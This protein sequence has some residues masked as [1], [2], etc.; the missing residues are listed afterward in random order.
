MKTTIL[1]LIL[2]VFT[3]PCSA[4]IIIVDDDGPADFNNVQSA[5]DDSNDGDIIVLFPGQYS[6]SGNRD[7]YFYGRAITVSSVAPE[8]EYIVS[9]TIVDCERQGRG[10]IFQ[11]GEDAN[12]VLDGL[13]ITNGRAGRG[14]GIYCSNNSSP[15]ISNCII[16][17]NL[18]EGRPPDL[19]GGGICCSNSS[20]IITWCTI[21]GNSASQGA[22][23][24]C[25]GPST[26]LIDNCVINDNSGD[27][28]YVSNAS[29]T[30][31][32]CTINNNSSTGVHSTDANFTLGYCDINL[33][34][35]SGIHC[36]GSTIAINNCTI[37][38]NSADKGGGIYCEESN[39]T[40]A[41]CSI[42]SNSAARDGGGIYCEESDVSFTEC[43]ITRNS[44][45]HEGGGICAEGHDNILTIS[46]CT[47]AGNSAEIGG[48]MYSSN[49]YA[50]LTNCTFSGNQSSGGGGLTYAGGMY[51]ITNCT[52]SSNTGGGIYNW[53]VY[54][55]VT[56]CILWGNT[57]STGAGE[58]AQI[59]E[60]R[61][62]V[63]FSCIQDDD[64]ND[65]YI[66]FSQT[67]NGNIDDNPM[68]VREPND[69]GDGWGIGDNDDFGDLHL[70]SSSPCIEA[71]T[72]NFLVGPNDMDIDGQ[73]RLIGF[74][75]DMGADE[76]GPI[77]I[78]T[79]PR[80]G[81]IWVNGSTH[82]VEWL[83][84]L[85]E[86]AVTVLFSEDAGSNWQT[87]E[88][89][90]PVSD[91]YLWQLPDG[92]DS[93]ECL[94]KVVPSVPDSNV[95]AIESG[96]FEI[97]PYSAS[98]AVAS[99]WETLGG[100]FE[101][102]G[103]SENIGP[104]VGCVKWKFETEG[105]VAT[106]VTI[107][108]GG[109]VHIACEDGK[110]YTLDSD[111]N[112][113]WSYDANSPLL[114]SPTIGPDG[115]V[116]VGGRD[117][118]LYAIDIDGEMR[119]TH[120]TDGPIS[121]SPAVS[122]DSNDV[123]V[124]SGD[125]IAYA[126]GQD[127]SELWSFETK[128]PGAIPSGSIFASPAIGAD[129][130]VYV[131]GLYDP[132]LYAI[133]PNDGGLKWACGF[134]SQGWPFASPVIA[135]DGTIYQTLL[136]DS[137]MY[138][139]EPNDGTIIWTTNLADP[140]SGWFDPNYG[141]DYG[142]A[143]GWSEPAL[144]PDGTIYVSFDDPYLRAVEPNG[145]IKWVTKL[146]TLGGFTLAVGND[147]LVYA[148]SDDGQLFVVD[149]DGEGVALFESDSWLNFPV[150][151]ADNELIVSDGNDG[152]LLVSDANNTIWAISRQGC[153]DSNFDGTIDY[154]D[155]AFL[156]AK[157]L[158][159][160]DTGPPCNYEGEQMYLPADIDRDRYVR[161]GDL[162]MIGGLWQGSEK[163]LMPWPPPPSPANTPD[164]Y[165]GATS[166]STR[167]HLRWIA[168]S[169]AAWHDVY[170]G[171]DNP[172]PSVAKRW[173]ATTF[174][175]G[176]MEESTKYYWRIDEVNTNGTATGELWS[177]TTGSGGSTTR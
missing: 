151:G 7:I 136:S 112:L 89:D 57:T 106:S 65:D 58:D 152:S 16:A 169:Y 129:G 154:N 24:S 125:G 148:A 69:G 130:T 104:D 17:G 63:F 159:C 124:C 43:S 161:F 35:I 28:I 105:A 160:T 34:S 26:A 88:S 173:T 54:P 163:L 143:V 31:T 9:I 20:P 33:N 48:G 44:A 10:F 70:Q 37:S 137:N 40:I 62:D 176:S 13:T 121:S 41:E 47:F 111:G 51:T 2:L 142:Y 133:D 167:V 78:V 174:N 39:V 98:S 117:G 102:T 122:Q 95:S 158:E 93:N 14:S 157:W 139:I 94:I 49:N 22:G 45:M 72:G 4:G 147:G 77:I 55:V 42:T 74:S 131:G 29:P 132:N 50:T 18:V 175:P 23:I 126:L 46:L 134:E 164:P 115:T 5:I 144:G 118:R 76:V 103:L 138:A 168:G 155:I 86:G 116:Y 145:S 84:D 60:S 146:G 6:G 85:Y 99:N 87:V 114:S 32:N 153:R 166:I 92:V 83:G 120:T 64:P 25:S 3:V 59:Y 80:G 119:W 100:G 11:S 177:F 71:G 53:N 67:D 30:I 21:T 19:N 140:Y 123:Y 81:E 127:G 156:A 36:L 66:P 27:G 110:L 91:S 15:T 52:I 141:E 82:E 1:V 97:R 150:I 149:A 171:T 101:R 90:I 162:A 75:V 170:F 107:G 165:N 113:L 12:S 172:P 108:T 109:R 128:G 56:N 68:F 79:K 96:L 61:A 73:P 38:G 8:D 135:E